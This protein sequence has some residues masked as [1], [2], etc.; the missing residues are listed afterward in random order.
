MAM[1]GY[2]EQTCKVLRY[3]KENSGVGLTV[4]EIASALNLQARSVNG[5]MLSLSNKGLVVKDK[6][7][8]GVVRVRL[9]DAGAKVDVY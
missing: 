3:M 6:S 1:S 8:E 5:T 2:S 9:T 7:D 4:K